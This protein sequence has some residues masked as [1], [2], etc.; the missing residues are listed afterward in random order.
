[1][2]QPSSAT[3]PLL[4]KPTILVDATSPVPREEQIKRHIRELQFDMKPSGTRDTF[5]AFKMIEEEFGPVELGFQSNSSKSKLPDN[6]LLSSESP[7]LKVSELITFN[8]KALTE[9]ISKVKQKKID[10]DQVLELKRQKAL[11]IVQAD[12]KAKLSDRKQSFNELIKI[13]GSDAKSELRKLAIMR[14]DALLKQTF[15]ELKRGIASL[16]QLSTQDLG[17]LLEAREAL[18]LASPS[19]DFG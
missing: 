16:S 4:K 8:R 5:D 19:N 2:S 13:S 12:N 14:R 10:L 18:R 11:K 1:M 17:Y 9:F 6:V 7:W 15:D 3:T